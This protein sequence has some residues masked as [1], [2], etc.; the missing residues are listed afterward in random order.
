MV[1]LI[2]QSRAFEQQINMIKEAKTTDEAGA[3]MLKGS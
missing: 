3:S 1:K 2:D